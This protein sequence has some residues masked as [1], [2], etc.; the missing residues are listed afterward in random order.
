[1]FYC[2]SQICNRLKISCLVADFCETWRHPNSV[3]M[4]WNLS[5]RRWI[6]V[7]LLSRRIQKK[8]SCVDWLSVASGT[9]RSAKVAL[10]DDNKSRKRYLNNAITMPCTIGKSTKASQLKCLKFWGRFKPKGRLR[11]ERRERKEWCTMYIYL[12]RPNKLLELHQREEI[13]SQITAIGK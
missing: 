13:K 4:H 1:M 10:T 6:S 5:S 12:H 9:P 3:W 8:V 11:A 7:Q 2:S